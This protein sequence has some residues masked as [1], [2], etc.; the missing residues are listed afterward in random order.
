MNN[1]DS[2]DS[3][4]KANFHD[5]LNALDALMAQHGRVFLIGAGCSKCAGLPLMEEL[6][7]KVLYS[8]V[9]DADTIDI[10]KG[11][12]DSFTGASGPNIE[13]Y[14]SEIIDLLAIAERRAERGATDNQVFIKGKQYSGQKLRE[15][16]E[17]IKRTISDIIEC[18]DKK[19]EVAVHRE[20]VKAVH[21]PIR[22]GKTD[23]LGCVDYLCLNY[24]TLLE[25]ALALEKIS[26]S[27]GLDGGV[28]GWWNPSVFE[29]DGLSSR[30]F[31]LHGSINWC[32]FDGDPL[33]RRVAGNVN[34]QS[35]GDKKILIWPASTK[36]RETQRDPYAQLAE[37][38]RRAL[39]AVPGSQKILITCGYR[40]GD[41]HINL[42]I[43]RA[44]HESEGR[45]TVVVFTSDNEP[46]DQL[47]KWHDDPV[48]TEQILI[49]ANRGFFHGSNKTLSDV[50]LL[51]WKFE[52]LT[53]LL[54]GER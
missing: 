49:F 44:L 16:T 10:L 7:S 2:F 30:I 46:Q 12:Q 26:F 17:K 50:D 34:V 39:R 28:T 41:S 3:L 45:L 6:T 23:G 47:K 8:G 36:Y 40:F 51:W 18:G 21:R 38:G 33:P 22:P 11:I 53:R 13:D 25:D 9:L 54:G 43:D 4:R 19:I 42:E 24:D 31:K 27:D 52:N 15:S 29:R 1:A 32:E 20:F 37:H 5:A 48:I 14:L 35:E